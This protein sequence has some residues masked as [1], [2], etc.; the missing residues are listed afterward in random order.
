MHI[1]GL[2]RYSRLGASSRLRSYQYEPAW[3]DSGI[4]VTWRPL[5]GD[6]YLADLYQHRRRRPRRVLSAYMQRLRALG[7]SGRFDLVWVEK[8]ALPWVPSPIDPGLLRNGPP[9]V[10]DY[11][12]A[13]FHYYDQSRHGA[14]RLLLGNKIAN[15]MRHAAIVVAGNPYLAQ[16]ARDAGGKRIE[17]IPTVVDLRRYELNMRLPGRGFSIGW[18]GS[19]ST[20][21]MI[22][23]LAPVLVRVLDADSDRLVTVGARFDEP[24]LPHH[25]IRPWTEA[26]EVDDI[27]QFDVGV[28]P[29]VDQPFERGKCGYKLIQYMACGLPVVASPVGVN[30]EI[31]QDGVNGFLASSDDD[32]LQ[33][34]ARLKADPGLRARMGT[35][36]RK[37]VE[38]K[39]CLQV[40]APRLT[41]LLRSIA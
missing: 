28:M 2:T 25:D 10:V 35:A 11:D 5:F 17:I 19:P 32:W 12:D 30:V 40:T 8:E 41:E 21:R 23:R 31:V 29:L 16:H 4:D 36:G 34:I 7:Q 38:Q 14:V 15:V 37:L 13:V 6:D 20:Q 24:L 3:A 18:I 39:Y 27:R 9:Y 22:A 33:A 26:S 1:V